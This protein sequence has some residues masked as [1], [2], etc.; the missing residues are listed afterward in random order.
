M[1]STASSGGA[2]STAR[3]LAIEVRLR[4][5]SWNVHGCVGSDGRFDPERVAA[6][7]AAYRPD[8]ALLQE[9]GDLS[10]VHPPIDQATLLAEALE[11]TPSVGVTVPRVPF[12]YGVVTL[13][14]AALV[15]GPRELWDLS[16]PPYEP[17]ACMVVSINA[18]MTGFV[19]R[20]ANLHLGLRRHERR[21]QLGRLLDERG[22]RLGDGRPLVLAGD[23]NDWP[24]GPVSR[25]LAATLTDAALA[26][27][28]KP[29]PTFPSRWPLLRL[30]R[31]YVGGSVRVLACSVDDGPHARRASDHLPLLAD[32]TLDALDGN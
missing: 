11:M 23:F 31:L 14:G 29:P 2:T 8:L 22:P 17:R 16:V 4:V 26:A 1:R 15:S 21:R 10:G 9:V 25:T 7:I 3:A 19:L 28:G 27:T 24:P 12:G 20:T 32:L 18:R 6:V 30:D 13:A 5:L